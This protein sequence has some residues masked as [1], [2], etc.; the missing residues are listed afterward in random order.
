[1][2]YERIPEIPAYKISIEG[3]VMSPYGRILKQCDNGSGYM[4]VCIYKKTYLVHRLVAE[5]YLEKPE[6]CNIV[7]HIDNNPKNN[8]VSNLKWSN[9]SQNV[10]NAY[11]DGLV[12]CRKGKNNPNYRNGKYTKK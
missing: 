2:N 12:T 11:R 8:H 9:Q 1:M 6:G 5:T 4:R 3:E 7:E 10:K